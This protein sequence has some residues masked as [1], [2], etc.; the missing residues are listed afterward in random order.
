M[1]KVHLTSILFTTFALSVVVWL[2]IAFRPVGFYHRMYPS[3]EIIKWFWLFVAMLLF[4]FACYRY[5]LRWVLLRKVKKVAKGV[6]DIEKVDKSLL[7]RLFSMT[8]KDREGTFIETNGIL[9]FFLIF[10]LVASFILEGLS[11]LAR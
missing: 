7:K 10:T 8:K 2:F 11:Y 9:I 3:I 4:T 5:C 6:V 1:R